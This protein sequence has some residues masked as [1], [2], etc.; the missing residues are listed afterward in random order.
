MYY[1]NKHA[2]SG[3]IYLIKLRRQ[4]MGWAKA[5]Q[6][7]RIKLNQNSFFFFLSFLLFIHVADSYARE[8]TTLSFVAC[9]NITNITNTS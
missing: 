9:S 5:F 7:H 4:E 1:I 6:V 3:C 8:A 2:K